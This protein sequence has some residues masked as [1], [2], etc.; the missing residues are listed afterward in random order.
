MPK[1]T[2]SR[3]EVEDDLLPRVCVLTG[4]P[5]DDVKVKRFVWMPSWVYVTLLAGLL[6]YVVIALV[7]QKT[8]AVRVPLVRSKHAHWLVRQLFAVIGILAALA[9]FFFGVV[10][11]MDEFDQNSQQLGG[12]LMAAGGVLFFGVLLVAAILNQS[13]V[14]PTEIT[15]REITLTGVHENFVVALEEDRDR[16]EEAYERRRKERRAKRRQHDPHDD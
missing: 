13:A 5:T 1:V 11:S 6:P 4:V 12:I 3:R 16:E 2:L 8:M 7:L 10:K 9:V 14:R 15:D